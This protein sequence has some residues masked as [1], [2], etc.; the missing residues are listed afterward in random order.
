M[1]IYDIYGSIEQDGTVEIRFNMQR[2]QL[3][4]PP[5]P[6]GTRQIYLPCGCCGIVKHV[7]VNVVS[8]LCNTCAKG[9][10]LND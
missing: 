9:G 1:T 10:N 3:E 5:L 6:D 2:H 8:F 7:N 4:A